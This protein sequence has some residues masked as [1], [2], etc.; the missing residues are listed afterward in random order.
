METAALV[1]YQ[2]Q[3]SLAEMRALPPSFSP[4]LLFSHAEMQ[5]VPGQP[6]SRIRTSCTYSFLQE[7]TKSS[8]FHMDGKKMPTV[9]GSRRQ[10]PSSCHQ[11]RQLQMKRKQGCIPALHL[12]SLMLKSLAYLQN[13]VGKKKKKK[14]Q[15]L[16]IVY[17]YTIFRIQYLKQFLKQF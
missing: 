5:P 4:R 16:Y 11:F 17:E 12:H 6:Q 15:M 8:P 10:I 2:F 7:A 14:V 13:T 9:S 1:L 3:D